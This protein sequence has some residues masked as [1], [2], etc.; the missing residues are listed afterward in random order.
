M[1]PF[2]VIIVGGSVTGL[3]L[4][5]MF[6]RSGI[7]FVVLEKHENIAPELGACLGLLPNGLR[8]LDQLGCY[9]ALKKLSQP[10]NALD[11]YDELGN[12]IGKM[13]ELGTWM[14]ELLGYKNE[15]LDRRQVIEV[16][17][18]NLESK[19]KIHT[20]CKVS[21]IEIS[22]TGVFVELENGDIF[23]GDIVIG[24]DGIHSRVLQEMQRHAEIDNPGNKSF[25]KDNFK[26]TYKALVGIGKAREGISQDQGFKN[27]REGRS[28]LCVGGLDRKFYFSLFV[29]NQEV[30]Q[31]DAIPRYTEQDRD[32]LVT[33]YKDDIVYP[34][35]TFGEIYQ[36][37]ICSTL[38]PIEEGMLPNCFYKRMVLSTPLFGQGGNDAI[39]S[40]AYLVNGLTSITEGHE[41]PDEVRLHSVFLDYQQTRTPENL[42]HV[43]GGQVTHAM[44]SFAKPALK[45]IQLRLA[46]ILPAQIKWNA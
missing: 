18:E 25:S 38:L 44:D 14:E 4:A 16:L 28:Y 15:N 41:S 26:C 24:A 35:L 46:P 13:P 36:N 7:D 6:E 3:A 22:M 11:S 21:K 43:I 30:T 34:G 10:M 29:R 31:G 37:R 20:S 5:N 32:A 12:L 8:I 23:D 42:A 45:F 17:F 33:T 19:S 1:A 40:S 39:V 27:F 2:K 9:D